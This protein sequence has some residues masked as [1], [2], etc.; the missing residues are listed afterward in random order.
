MRIL[1]VEDN[2]EKFRRIAECLTGVD[3][4]GSDQIENCRDSLAAK[5]LLLRNSYDL[6]ILDIALPERIDSLPS[7]DAGIRLLEEISERDR[8]IVPDHIVGLTGFANLHADARD[9]F[10]LRTWTVIQYEERSRDWSEQL[11][12]RVEHVI[13]A[14]SHKHAGE[15][16]R[17]ELAII[18]AVDD[19][20][21]ASVK[22]LPCGWKVTAVPGDATVYY[23]GSTTRSG[24]RVMAH[25]A[26]CS[27]MGMPA[28]A[29]LAMKVIHAFR[30]KYLAMVGIAAG[31]FGKA[32]PGDVLA[33]D[34]SWDYGSGEHYR[35]DGEPRFA[36]APHQIP[37]DVE[38][39]SRIKLLSED[40]Q[41]LAKIRADWPGDKPDFPLKIRVGPVASG[42]AV[43]A[44]ED[45]LGQVGDQHRQLLGVEME[46]Y[47]I[48]AA[49]VECSA[50]RPIPVAIKSVCDFGDGNKDDRYQRYAA[51]T[52]AQVLL[53][54]FS[55]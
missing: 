4:L 46:A 15:S 55:D 32:N 8:Y 20:E 13:A 38:L 34:P 23:Q 24:E 2:G 33:V 27:R 30:P 14:R 25:A 31:V 53:K 18:C 47:S 10:A 39:R 42:A 29:I 28:A 40:D 45:R 6:L 11:R 19:P 12:S 54:L 9:R 22:R 49:A 26:S 16:Y 37:L 41:V 51:Y 50:P 5:R 3:G 17:S 35:V 48:F 43:V 21:M 36:A 44:D 7:P 1:V 52:S